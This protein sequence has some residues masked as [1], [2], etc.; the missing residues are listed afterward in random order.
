VKL[1]CKFGFHYWRLLGFTN[2]TLSDS[3]EE[4]RRCG[5]GRATWCHGQAYTK[6]TPEQMATYKKNC[7][8]PT[9]PN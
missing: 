6:Y 9:E 3:L 5:A 7:A 4:C 1:L 2:L 8:L